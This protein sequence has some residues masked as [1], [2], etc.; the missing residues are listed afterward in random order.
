MVPSPA[1]LFILFTSLS[2]NWCQRRAG[3][4]GP[5]LIEKN[6]RLEEKTIL[7]DILSEKTYDPRIRP[8]ALNS[9]DGPTFIKVNL[10]IRSID[11]I[12][13]VKMEFSVQITF[14]QKWFDDRL[15]FAHKVSP[16][17][18]DK[19]KYLTITEPG[20][21]WMPDTFFRNER[22]G[23]MHNV[24]VPNLYIRIYA[25]GLV[26]FSI[27]VSLTLSCPMN[28]K[29]YPL[30]RQMCPMQIA[31][32]GWATDDLV[33]LWKKE[34]PVQ[35]GSG[36]SLPRF[37]IEKYSSDY[38]NVNTST[39]EYSCLLME[40]TLKREFSY[41]MLTIY[42]PTCMLVIVSWFSFWIDP[43][44]VPA[45]VALGVTTLLTMSTKTAS[46]SN[47]LPP[48]AYTKAVDLWTG[49]CIF[50]VFFA[51]LEYTAVNA[52]ARTDAKRLTAA[53]SR[54]S[55]GKEEDEEGNTYCELA[56]LPKRKNNWI[57]QW[58]GRFPS[59]AKK[60]DVV[61]RILFPIIF[62]S[63]NLVYWGYYLNKEA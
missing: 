5:I 55:N 28:L 29:L 18:K 44:A 6:Q 20:K 30:D 50:F 3:R 38:C 19:I 22:F 14:R 40:L 31:S 32:Y 2:L 35:I 41:Y 47:S 43:K 45:R 8:S 21:V 61:S 46:I 34:D 17:M 36:I 53:K 27:R 37:V 48:V 10:M 51:L 39:G 11:K 24:L 60:I 63:F 56:L 1:S 15:Q 59:R 9:S 58:L 62:A 49:V 33:Y 16:A 42:V 54:Q 12:D 57:L 25:D 4:R 26:L 52:A 7:D 13:D 23:R